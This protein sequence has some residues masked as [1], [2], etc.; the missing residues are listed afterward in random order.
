MAIYTPP[1][2]IDEWRSSLVGM[3]LGLMLLFGPLDLAY[4]MARG[5]VG[6][7]SDAAPA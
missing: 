6:R 2:P 7:Q 5:V 3:A 1:G 4:W